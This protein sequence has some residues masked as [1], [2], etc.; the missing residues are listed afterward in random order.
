MAALGAAVSCSSKGGN[1]QDLSGFPDESA[2]NKV[3]VQV[4]SYSDVSQDETYSSTVQAFVINNVVPQSGNRIAKIN[5]EVGDFVKKNQVLAEMDRL[6]LVQTKLKLANDSTELVRLQKL[7]TEGGI[8]AS[9]LEAIQ[10]AYDVSKT[11]Y[12]NLLD[13]TIL[14]SPLNGV[15]TARNYDAGDMYAM[16]SPIYVV[17]QISP[18]KLYVGVSETDYTKVKVG[19][20]VSIEADALPGRVFEGTVT[21][22]HPTIDAATHTFNVEVNVPNRDY[23]LRPGM[24]A[25]VN[26]VFGINH[27]IV[28]EDSAI[29][30][31]QG[32]GQ[33]LVYVVNSD[34]TVSSKYIVLGK[35]FDTKY[36]VLSGIDEGDK[37]VVKG[38]AALKNGTS[39]EVVDL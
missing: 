22:I 29:V 36:E 20:N 19:D 3:S 38:N 26:I 12:E 33:R 25:R 31:Q 28:V 16:T 18:V 14:R 8:A 27:S 39:V 4:A 37:V 10:L 15:V 1:T 34:N 21:R 32:S 24:F 2:V 5:V 6:S 11:S 17:Q 7:Y 9:D 13:N 23:A 35:H 30:K